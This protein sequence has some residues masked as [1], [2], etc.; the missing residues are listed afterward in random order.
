MHLGAAS[1]GGSSVSRSQD[2]GDFPVFRISPEES[3]IKFDV[4]R[5]C[6]PFIGIADRVEVSVSP[7]AERISGP[8]VPLSNNQLAL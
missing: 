1:A 2:A 8:P 6:L 7:K 4:E 5:P 3:K